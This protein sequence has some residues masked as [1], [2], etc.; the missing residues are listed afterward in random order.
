MSIDYIKIDYL[1]VHQPIG[2]FYIGSIKWQDLLTIAEA[3]IRKIEKEGGKENSFD[4]YL[5][6][7][8]TLSPNRI[9]EIG[10]YVNTIDA[11]FPT[12]II[13]HIKSKE[14]FLE[15]KSIDEHD[16]D[17]VEDNRDKVTEIVNIKID[18]NKLEIRSDSKV[19]KILDGQ[20]R[21]EG[22]KN[23]LSNHVGEEFPTFDFNVTIFVD[24]DIDDQAQI[25][26][27]INKAQ[28]KVNKSL[29]YDLFEYAKHRSP[30]KTAHDIVRLLNKLPDS[31]F[32]RKIKILGVA[33]NTATETIAQ[34]TLVELIIDY[35][36]KDPMK[37]RDELRKSSLFSKNKLE[38]LKDE[39]EIKRR[40]FR[41]LF[42]QEK[43][44]LIM[45][46][47]WNYFKAVE[48][49]WPKVWTPQGDEE[50]LILNRTTGVIA[51]MRFLKEIYIHLG[52]KDE[53]VSY[54]EFKEI[55]DKVDIDDSELT[56][57]NYVPG[58]SGQ[59]KLF[60]DFKNALS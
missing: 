33:E 47:L 20:H 13:L 19:A 25:F 16:S 59:S 46:I 17:H 9:T 7:Q 54:D 32:Y 41:N 34:A 60:H 51:L 6:I 39:K 31:P 23:G 36:S 58:S 11:T 43:D 14:K 49:R 21:I 37:D 52:K 18:A 22:L 27:I 24:L 38:L 57:T 40:I 29:V 55:L 42:I 1:K 45:R 8:R 56:K 5:G 44:E 10:E 28:T 30:Q 50:G 4:S 3:D 35:I 12:S 2:T 48:D 26:S 53:I 15:G